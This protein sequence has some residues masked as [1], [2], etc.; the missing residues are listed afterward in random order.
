M[1]ALRRA[2]AAHC[3]RMDAF[4]STLRV[5]R[6]AGHGVLRSNSAT[7]GAPPCGRPASGTHGAAP[8][9]IRV[10]L[11]S[12]AAKPSSTA[13]HGVLRSFLPSS[14]GP[15]AAR[16]LAG[17]SLRTPLSAGHG[18]LRSF[19]PA[20]PVPAGMMGQPAPQF[21]AAGDRW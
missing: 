14:P 12:S 6:T 18:V 4:F 17:T 2:A 8:T 13:G 7:V 9:S 1:V 21:V 11:R 16:L 5:R 3:R 20:G 15:R 19:S 10:H